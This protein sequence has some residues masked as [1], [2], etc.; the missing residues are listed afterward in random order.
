MVKLKLVLEKYSKQ[1]VSLGRAAE[2]ARM[3]LEDFLKVAA[4]KKISLNYSLESLER[5]FKA[6]AM[7]K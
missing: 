1:L 3:P 2:L 5:D 6:A 4:E 7:S